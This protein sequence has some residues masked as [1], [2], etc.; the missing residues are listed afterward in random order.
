[1]KDSFYLKRIQGELENNFVEPCVM[2]YTT[3]DGKANFNKVEK[4]TD[5]MVLSCGY[6]SDGKFLSGMIAIKDE[7]AEKI[8]NDLR[9]WMSDSNVSRI[10]SI[11]RGSADE[12]FEISTYHYDENLDKKIGDIVYFGDLD[13]TVVMYK[14][15]GEDRE[16]E[17]I[18]ETSI[19]TVIE[20]ISDLNLGRIINCDFK[21]DTKQI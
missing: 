9:N 11:C 3:S 13:G 19:D 21:N 12:A 18:G 5:S 1:M 4:L 17:Y 20:A 14:D 7:F 10:I 6:T 15:A 16:L 8:D 2:E